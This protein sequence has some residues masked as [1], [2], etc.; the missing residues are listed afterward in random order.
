MTLKVGYVQELYAEP[1]YFD[2]AR[3]GLTLVEMR[4]SALAAAAANGEIDAAP[5]PLVDCFRLADRFQPVAGFGIASVQHTGSVF[6]HAIKPMEALSGARIGLMDTGSTESWLVRLLLRLK[7]QVQGVTYVPLHEPYDAVLV[8]GNQGLRQRRGVQGFPHQY[9]LGTEWYAWTGLP[10]VF[11]RW[12]VRQDVAS[13]AKALL[14]D[15]LYVGLEE[16]VNAVYQLADPRDDLRMLPREITAYIRG[17]RYFLRLPEQ[18]AIDQFHHYLQQ[19]DGS[20]TR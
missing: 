16:G 2:M 12:L 14:E 18:R 20:V 3:R 11:A 9:D 15:A 8:A 17:L 4:P 5:M 1:C 19:L 6:L 10:W 13:P 7:Y